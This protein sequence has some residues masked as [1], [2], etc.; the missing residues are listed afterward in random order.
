[1]VEPVSSAARAAVARRGA[2]TPNLGIERMQRPALRITDH[3][4]LQPLW[5]LHRDAHMN[6][7]VLQQHLARR[8]E[9]RVA[10]G[11]ARQRAH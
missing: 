4:H 11:M 9:A 2:Q 3:R 7:A 8:I 1:M 5:S 10:L 6:G